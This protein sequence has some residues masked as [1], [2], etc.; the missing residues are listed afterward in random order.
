KSASREEE[1]LDWGDYPQ[2]HERRQGYLIHQFT[3]IKHGTQ[4][5]TRA[6][7]SAADGASIQH[8]VPCLRLSALST[9]RTTASKSCV[10]NS[11]RTRSCCDLSAIGGR[12]VFVSY[13]LLM[14]DPA[15]AAG[16]AGVLSVTSQGTFIAAP[17]PPPE[18]SF[19]GR[20]LSRQS[21][22]TFLNGLSGKDNQRAFSAGWVNG[23]K[24]LIN[25]VKQIEKGGA[26]G[27]L[28]LMVR[29]GDE[30]QLLL[31]EKS[32][33]SWITNDQLKKTRF[34]WI[35]WGFI[36]FSCWRPAGTPDTARYPKTFQTQKWREIAR[37]AD[38]LDTLV[39]K[40]ASRR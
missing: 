16:G 14:S 9:F 40:E 33:A 39:S 31:V 10:F 32:R 28:Q 30:W 17:A 4:A 6:T 15:G 27:R 2:T 13:L 8:C 5:E 12:R 3:L 7:K 26:A 38:F 20:L 21:S 36:N 29:G 22:S 35:I 11:H 23:G 1:P 37:G 24:E 19:H 34:A 18:S 25:P